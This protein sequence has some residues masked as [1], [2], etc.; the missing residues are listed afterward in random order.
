MYLH[1]VAHTCLPSA[2]LEVRGGS[3]NYCVTTNSFVKYSNDVRLSVIRLSGKREG[4]GAHILQMYWFDSICEVSSL[5]HLNFKGGLRR[6]DVLVIS[7]QFTIANKQRQ[8]VYR[9][10][11]GAIKFDTLNWFRGKVVR[12]RERSIFDPKL[13]KKR[14][15]SV[16]ILVI[17]VWMRLIFLH[18]N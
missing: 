5:I 18:I 16:L 4:V 7:S 11:L 8:E 10:L 9:E 1:M 17:W 2:S 3:L 14:T 13:S 12:L 15:Y 6:E